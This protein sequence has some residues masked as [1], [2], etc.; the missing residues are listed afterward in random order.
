MP[1]LFVRFHVFVLNECQLLNA[2]KLKSSKRTHTKLFKQC[3]PKW[4]VKLGEN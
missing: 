1:G 2:A 4:Q 3:Y